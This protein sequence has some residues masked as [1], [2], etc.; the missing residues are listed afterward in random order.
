MAVFFYLKNAYYTMWHHGIMK[1][2][3]VIA[4][5]GHIPIFIK[6][7]RICIKTTYSSLHSL[8]LGAP[9]GSI[10]VVVLTGVTVNNIAT[11]GFL[12]GFVFLR[13]LM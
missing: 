9:Q 4:L 7:F 8:E 3:H 10:L 6:H 13:S 2:F 5:R 11:T 12:G 1:D